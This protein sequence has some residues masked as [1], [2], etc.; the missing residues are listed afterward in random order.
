MEKFNY[1]NSAVEGTAQE[2]IAGLSL[3]A[4]IYEQA[5]TT[6]KKR[7]GSKQKIINKHMDAMLKIASVASCTDYGICSIK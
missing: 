2:A 1:L 3:T 5:I 7:F 4:A 6:L